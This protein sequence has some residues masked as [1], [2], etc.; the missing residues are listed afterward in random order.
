MGGAPFVREWKFTEDYF[1]PHV[2]SDPTQWYEAWD[3]LYATSLCGNVPSASDL[4]G[5]KLTARLIVSPS[6]AHVSTTITLAPDTDK[7]T[8]RTT[9]TPRKGARAKPGDTIKIRME[10]SEEYVDRQRE[11]WQ[12]G[13]KKLQLIDQGPNPVVTPHWEG[14]QMRAGPRWY[15]RSARR[16]AHPQWPR[17][18]DAAARAPARA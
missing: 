8:L 16:D 15:G 13:A 12:T 17:R 6:K 10:A 4:P 7:P 1:P 14:D 2:I 18:F 5:A 9:S 11:G 3:L